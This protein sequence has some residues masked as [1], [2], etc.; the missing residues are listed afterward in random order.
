LIETRQDVPLEAHLALE[1]LEGEE[2]RTQLVEGNAPGS[3]LLVKST[4]VVVQLGSTLL[5]TALLLRTVDSRSA[6]SSKRRSASRPMATRKPKYRSAH[7][8]ERRKWALRVATG[9]VACARC[10][11]LIEPGA[12]FDLDHADDGSGRYIGI[13]HVHC[14]RRAGALRGAA[15]RRAAQHGNAYSAREL[16]RMRKQRR[17]ALERWF[18]RDW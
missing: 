15:L 3:S 11:F 12:K 6:R 7:V 5:K 2:L 18:S 4:D 14:N 13:S 9:T 8:A 16:G 10:G 1:T 17:E